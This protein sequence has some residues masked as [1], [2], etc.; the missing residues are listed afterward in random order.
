MSPVMQSSSISMNL[1]P[2]TV[3]TPV[4]ASPAPEEL[5]LYHRLSLVETLWE[6]VLQS[7]CGQELVDLLNELR[8]WR[9]PEEQDLGKAEN[10]LEE[11]TERIEKL[12][13]DDA[14]RAARAFA[15]YFQLI[16]IV[17]Q[18]YE[19]REQER[20]R[21]E[22]TQQL[23]FAEEAGNEERVIPYRDLGFTK[24]GRPHE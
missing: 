15:L 12:E 21:W 17:E 7:E 16:N 1:N 5:V 19:K 9:S 11:V 3:D 23:S 2:V 14:I 24:K 18:H 20:N 10:L 13:L 8:S 22:A 6:K 4:T